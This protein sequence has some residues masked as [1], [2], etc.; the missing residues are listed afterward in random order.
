MISRK[1]HLFMAAAFAAHGAVAHAQEAPA[2]AFG[3]EEVVV[4]AQK[5]A[6]NVQDVPISVTAFSGKALEAAGVQDVRDLRRIAPNLN[7]TT[8]AQQ[9]NTRVMIRGI[10]TAGNTAIEPS[11]ASFVD[12]IYIPRVGA[13]LAGLND[14]GSVEVLRGPQGTLFGR[15]ASMGA[16]NMRTTDPQRDLTSELWAQAGNYG[17]RRATAIL[18]VP[19]NDTLQTRVAVLGFRSDGFGRDE[20]TG[21]R[22]G[23]NTGFSLR[24]A[25]KWEIRPELTWTVKGDYQNLSGD[26]SNVVTVISSTVTAQALANWRTRLDPDGAGPLAADLPLL[27]GTYRRRVRGTNGG[28]VK[29]YQTG[30]ASELSW[31]APGG[32]QLKL[33][34]GYRDWHDQQFEAAAQYLPVPLQTRRGSFDSQSHSEELQL[35]SPPDL[36]GGHFSYVAGLYYFTEEYDIG[37]ATDFYDAYCNLYLRNTS[38]AARVAMCLADPK[39]NVSVSNF[40]QTTD[41]YAAYFQGTYELTEQLSFTGG[42]RYSKDEKTGVFRAQRNNRVAPAAPEV[43]DLSLDADKVTYRLNASYKPTDGIML[44]AS[45][46]TGFK[47]GGFDASTG[48]TAALGAAA[49]TFNPESTKNTEIGIKSELFDRRLI[50]NATLFRTDITEYQF[51]SYDGLQFRVRNNGEVRQ[52]GIELDTVARPIRPLTLTFSVAYLD[53]EYTDFRGAPPLPGLTTPQDLTGERLPYSPKWQGAASAQYVGDLPGGMSWLVRGDMS[54]TSKLNVSAAGDNN[55]DAVQAGYELFSARI[56]L[57]GPQ[58][59]WELA[60]VGQNLTNKA[61]CTGIFNQPQNAALGLDRATGGTV[62]RCTLNEP[63]TLAVEARARF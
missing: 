4:T 61:F 10:G 57:R 51:R 48:T 17:R 19:V 29:D 21:E 41:S 27:D 28:D 23:R 56:A 20:L 1:T 6:E 49:R 47:S 25:V 37:Q 2:E 43:T 8:S 46:A 58:E 32:Y 24:G 18:N 55:P 63:R 59:K 26:G 9:T 52:Q 14:I 40:S 15:N 22:V 16:I 30:V 60:F 62:L 3:V 54:F 42:I 36:L 50:A 33:I 31:E 45:Y 34:S 13:L 35:L 11:V 38:T 53:S 39:T 7:L 12:G 44:F 5:R